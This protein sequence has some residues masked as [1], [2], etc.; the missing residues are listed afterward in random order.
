MDRLGIERSGIRPGVKCGKCFTV[1]MKRVYSTWVCSYCG[2]HDKEA[3]ITTLQ[4][5]QLFFGSEATSRDVKWW[6]GID[7]KDLTSRILKS[8]IEKYSGNNKN[9]VYTLKFEPWR[10]DAFL[11]HEM[12][13]R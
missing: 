6:L 8:C 1:G 11:T 4:E 5:Y 2:C 13:K 9:R 12:K 7:N 10:L 3:H